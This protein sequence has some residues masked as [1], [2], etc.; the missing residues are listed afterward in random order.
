MSVFTSLWRGE[1]GQDLIE[2]AL[3]LSFV[4]LAA[5]AIF[6]QAGVTLKGIWETTNKVLSNANSVAATS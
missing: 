5:A 6:I 2:Y 1:E 4:A 3:L